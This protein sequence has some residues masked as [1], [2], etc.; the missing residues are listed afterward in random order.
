MN[1]QT[2]IPSHVELMFWFKRQVMG[3]PL[4]K[5]HNVIIMIG[6][7]GEIKSENRSIWDGTVLGRWSGKASVRNLHLIKQ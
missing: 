5:M 7:K 2:P 3:N 6:G 1:K 4:G